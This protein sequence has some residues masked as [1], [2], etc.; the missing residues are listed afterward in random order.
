MDDDA[1]VDLDV[2]LGDE[3][4]AGRVRVAHDLTAPGVRWTRTDGQMISCQGKEEDAEM[5][6]A[7]FP[8]QRVLTK[9]ACAHP[10]ARVAVDVRADAQR[11]LRARV[12]GLHA[13]AGVVAQVPDEQRH[14]R[15]GQSA[16]SARNGDSIEPD[17]TG[18]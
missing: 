17:F 10:D 7:A 12:N 15:P 11:V 3:S 14:L 16:Q 9:G 1:A 4:L 5:P 13:P 6:V 18:V 2:G 8:V